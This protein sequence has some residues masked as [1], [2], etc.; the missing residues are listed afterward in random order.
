MPMLRD[1]RKY[2]NK[3]DSQDQIS[4]H[5][6]TKLQAEC[7]QGLKYLKKIDPKL[8]LGVTEVDKVLEEDEKRQKLK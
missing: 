4:K 6:D 7:I 8:F 3:I 1:R 2:L 5:I